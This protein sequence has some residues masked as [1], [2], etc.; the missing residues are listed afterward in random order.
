MASSDVFADLAAESALDFDAACCADVDEEPELKGAGAAA[1]VV[2]SSAKAKASS[3]TKTAKKKEKESVG[4]GKGPRLNLTQLLSPISP[5]PDMTALTTV[6]VTQPAPP[7]RKTKSHEKREQPMGPVPVPVWPQYTVKNDDAE[8]TYAVAARTER[9]IQDILQ[10][11]KPKKATQPLC[12]AVL[13]N[14]MNNIHEQLVAG[15]AKSGS[16][17]LEELQEEEIVSGRKAKSR[18]N[19]CTRSRSGFSYRRVLRWT[20]EVSGY[21]LTVLNT[22]RSFAFEINPCACRFMNECVPNLF[23]RLYAKRCAGPDCVG[24]IDF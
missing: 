18:A 1:P 17:R 4:Q 2:T 24:R 16:K 23:V 12:R 15:L 8:M 22:A 13:H 7:G 21:E 9:W 3:K 10:L 5:T 6:F 11:T 20:I 19:G 14:F